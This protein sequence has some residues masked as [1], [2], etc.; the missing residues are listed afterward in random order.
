MLGSTRLF[1]QRQP[2]RWFSSSNFFDVL[3]LPSSFSVNEEELR[4]VYRQLMKE[5]HPDKHSNKSP[6][7]QNALEARASAVTR[8]YDTL[9]SPHSRSVHLLEVLGRPLEEAV[10]G[11]LVGNEFLMDVMELRED[12]DRTAPG[13]LEPLLQENLVRVD[14]TIQELVAAFAEES[15][16]HAL[17]LTARLQ[18]WNRIHETIREKME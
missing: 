7:D 13:S 6:E 14:E 12:V 18:Y 8:A 2:R 5:Y 11:E 1:L 16:D 3:G 10:S 4:S 17:E 15:L 9:K